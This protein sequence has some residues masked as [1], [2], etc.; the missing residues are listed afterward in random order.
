[1]EVQLTG[2]WHG[3]AKRIECMKLD[4]HLLCPEDFITNRVLVNSEGSSVES[5]RERY[6]QNLF[7]DM[8]QSHP[9]RELHSTTMNMLF[10]FQLFQCVVVPGRDVRP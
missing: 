3:C 9:N 10:T 5:T 8:I 7:A 6:L 1:V 4:C 2:G